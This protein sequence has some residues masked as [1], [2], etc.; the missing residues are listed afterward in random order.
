MISICGIIIGVLLC[1]NSHK[2]QPNIIYDTNHIADSINVANAKL[3][4]NIIKQETIIIYEK[5]KLKEKFIFIDSLSYDS[6]YGYW[7]NEA[8][9][10]K[11][12]FN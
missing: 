6:A 2:E 9:R 7:T 1:R 12:L 4:T 11:P 5:A 8:F 3:D 10:Y